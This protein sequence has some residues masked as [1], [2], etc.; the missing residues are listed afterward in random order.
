MSENT[1]S[2]YRMIKSSPEKVY[3]ALTEPYAIASWMP[4]YG[5]IGI[6]HHMDV[7][8]GGTYRM[9]FQNFTTGTMQSF[10]GEYLEV[11]PNEF[12][13]YQDRFDDQN[14]SGTMTN[15]IWI[16]QTSAG[17]ELKILQEGIPKAIPAEQCYLGWQDSLEKL[18]K[19][20]EPNIYD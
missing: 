14:L 4:P 12:I 8:A 18:I 16:R 20:V 7:R 3:R 5:F 19:L 17:T 13:K 2:L 10:G 11:R 15:T 6:T 1:V 9:S